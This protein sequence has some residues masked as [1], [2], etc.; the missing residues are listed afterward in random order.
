ML[1]GPKKQN[2]LRDPQMKRRERPDEVPSEDMQSLKRRQADAIGYY[3]EVGQHQGLYPK[4]RKTS[5]TRSS[6]RSWLFK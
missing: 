1:R 3:K 4:Q 6:A 2:T 5:R